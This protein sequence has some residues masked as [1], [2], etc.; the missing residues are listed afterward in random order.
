[1]TT[2]QGINNDAVEVHAMEA[3]VGANQGHFAERVL[4]VQR[5][6]SMVFQFSMTPQQATALAE[7]LVNAAAS[8]KAEGIGAA[9][10]V[11]I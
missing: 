9:D 4:I 2:I 8:L 6:G 5:N 7:A 1:M 3:F 10:G 11:V